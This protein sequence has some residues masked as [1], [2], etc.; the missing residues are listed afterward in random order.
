VRA[1]RSLRA[2][3]A[4]LERLEAVQRLVHEAGEPVLDVIEE[5]RVPV[6]EQAFLVVRALLDRDAEDVVELAELLLDGGVEGERALPPR[7]ARPRRPPPLRC[8]VVRRLL[9][10]LPRL[11]RARLARLDGLDGFVA[12]LRAE[13][14][15]RGSS[16][17]HL[18]RR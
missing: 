4:G 11:G 5:D 10:R 15:P 8:L 2:G 7:P 18:S 3:R 13:Y 9:S 6:R 1:D 17:A 12:R 14:G 16:R